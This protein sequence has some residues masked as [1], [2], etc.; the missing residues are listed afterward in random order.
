[1]Q[2]QRY[3]GRRWCALVLSSWDERNRSSISPIILCKLFSDC[4]SFTQLNVT[5]F[6]PLLIG[7]FNYFQEIKDV[8][9]PRNGRH[10]L[11]DLFCAADKRNT[12][13]SFQSKTTLKSVWQKSW[14]DF[15][16]NSSQIRICPSLDWEKQS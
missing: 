14:Y 10:S 5:C 1:M 2:Y 6:P 8:S 11:L 7:C 4:F 3:L 12:W 13:K 16:K 15:I 9:L